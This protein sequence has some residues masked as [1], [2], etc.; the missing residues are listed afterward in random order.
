[1]PDVVNFNFLGAGVV[2]FPIGNFLSFALGYS[3]L[4][5]SSLI[6]SDLLRDVRTR[7]ESSLG[8]IIAVY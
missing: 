2:F 6:L 8:L 5:I 7:A 3:Y 4:E 1:M